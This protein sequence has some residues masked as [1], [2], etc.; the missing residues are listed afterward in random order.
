MPYTILVA[1]LLTWNRG[2]T[3]EEIQAT[4][5]SAPQMI[6]FVVPVTYRIITIISSLFEPDFLGVGVIIIVVGSAVSVPASIKLGYSFVGVSLLLHELLQK[7]K[8]IQD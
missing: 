3:T 6:M 5:T 7:I 2:K 4:F 8:I 1:Y